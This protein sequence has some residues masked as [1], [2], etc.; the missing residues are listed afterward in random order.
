VIILAAV[1]AAYG[2]FAFLDN[3]LSETQINIASAALKRH[4]SNLFPCD[5][6][7]GE[8][9]LWRLHSPVFYGLLELVLLPTGYEYPSLPFRLMAPV[10]AMIFLCGMYALLYRQCRSWSV[11]VFVAVLSSAVTNTLGNAFWGAGPLELVTPMGICIALTPLVVLSFLQYAGST[12]APD[13]HQWRLLLVFACIGLM[14]NV[15]LIVAMNLAAVLLITYLGRMRFRL[16]SLPVA[17]GCAAA[18]VIGAMPYICYF[19]TLRAQ[20]A[21][22]GVQVSQKA[23]SESLRIG[24]FAALYPELAKS[25]LRWLVYVVLLCIP[26]GAALIRL[27]RFKVRELSSW[28]WFILGS[29]FVSIGL[30]GAGQLSGM[31]EQP[32][33]LIVAFLQASAFVMLP[34]YVLVAHSV[35]NL[36]RLVVVHRGLVRWACAAAMAAWLIPSDNCRIARHMAYDVTTMFMDEAEKPLRIQQLHAKRAEHAELQSIANWARNTDRNSV[37]ITNRNE[38]RMMARRSIDIHR[39]DVSYFYYLAPWR[40]G[41]W[42]DRL[43]RQGKLFQ[44]PPDVS[45]LVRF[46]V[47]LS[48]QQDF[49]EASDW[50]AIFPVALAPVGADKLLVRSAGSWGKYYRLYCIP[51]S[52]GPPDT[53]ASQPGTPSTAATPRR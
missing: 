50:F 26:A 22:P 16:S 8:S 21:A 20:L 3:D 32:G 18:A 7:L 27:E 2:Y 48:K 45:D 37:F 19:L 49:A 46:R 44:K 52:V 25:L 24:Y 15:Q 30:H 14:G 39:D 12:D 36:F 6:V 11:A 1:S 5:P 42:L 53:P 4:Q 38:F 13:R 35:T 10:T 31:A 17:A 34:L 41:A 9:Q 23:L 43:E 51:A 40:L 47:Y 33:P 29:L 28:V